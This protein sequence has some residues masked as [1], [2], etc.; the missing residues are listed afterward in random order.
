MGFFPFRQRFL[1]WLL[2]LLSASAAGVSGADGERIADRL[3]WPPVFERQFGNPVIV[4]RPAL[5]DRC[6][7]KFFPVAGRI[8]VPQSGGKGVSDNSD[9][10]LMDF[11]LG[12]IWER[13]LAP[14]SLPRNDRR[15]NMEELIPM[16][17]ERFFEI[18]RCRLA[19]RSSGCPSADAWWQVRMGQPLSVSRTHLMALCSISWDEPDRNNRGHYSF[20]VRRRGGDPGGDVILDFRAAW[21]LDRR[22]TLGEAFNRDD[23]LQL[24]SIRENLYDWLYTQ[25][26]H[27]NCNVSATFTAIHCE[28]IQLIRAFG[29]EARQAGPFRLVQKNCASL[30]VRFMNRL[31]PLDQPLSSPVVDLPLRAIDETA[32]RFGGKRGVVEIADVTEERGNRPSNSNHLRPAKPSREA[33]RPYQIL[34]QVEGIN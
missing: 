3:E 16:S 1:L 4:M 21:D 23:E 5:S 11:F 26:E 12:R 13:Y 6:E 15:M 8:A 27:R 32:E 24:E 17:R 29:D 33:S 10:L 30:G 2:C 18:G 7:V 22:P 25:T 14:E 31:L 34:L 28:Q 20:A 19:G 9:R